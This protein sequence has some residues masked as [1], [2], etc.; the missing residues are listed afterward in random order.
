[1]KKVTAVFDIGKTNKKFFLFDQSL[2]VIFKDNVEVREIKDEDGDPCDDLTTIINWMLTT[3]D[4]ALEMDGILITSLNFSTYG[5]SFVHIDKNG[6]VLT[7]LYNYLKPTGDKTEQNF[8]NTY[9]DKSVLARATA[10]PSLGMLNSGLQLYWL[11]HKRPEVYKQVAYSMHFPQ[12]LSYLFTGV[13]LSDFTSLGCHTALWDFDEKDYHHWVYSEGIDQKL[14]PLVTTDTSVHISYKGRRL[15][16]GVGIHDSSAALLPY[17]KTQKK[18]F[19]LLSTGTWNIALNPFNKNLL[20]FDDL[21]Q[22]CLNY[23]QPNAKP[24]RAARLFMGN[25]HQLQ[26]QK[27]KEKFPAANAGIAFDPELF[28]KIEKEDKKYFIFE[29]LPNINDKKQTSLD[30]LADFKTAYHQLIKELVDL[31]LNALNLAI[32]KN[33]PKKLFIDGGFVAND[34]FVKMLVI[35]LPKMKIISAES[36]MGSSIGAA[37]VLSNKKMSGKFL[38]KHFY[39][40]KHEA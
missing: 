11:K 20:S 17:L 25:E 3:F 34:L 37:I 2:K 5:A 33:K 14:P 36:A 23:M 12:Y 27:L 38:K 6:K 35:K 18:S 40:K 31:Q 15:K 9:G 39:T 30:E 32:G 8:Y 29:S 7:P 1:M 22:D 13:P 24:V 10:S 16:V 28:E 21:K 19:T 4:K 26:F